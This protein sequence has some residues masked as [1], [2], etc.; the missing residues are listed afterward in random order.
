MYSSSAAHVWRD[1]T[2]EQSRGEH[3]RVEPDANERHPERS[4][5][6]GDTQVA[7]EREAQAGA[8]RRAVDGGDRRDVDV[9]QAGEARVE[10]RHLVA[11]ERDVALARVQEVEVAARAER[12]PRAGDDDGAGVLH[13]LS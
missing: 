5:G 9:E 6:G 3:A 12:R 4:V 8:D 2:R 10:R 1:G 13:L 7:H 11:E